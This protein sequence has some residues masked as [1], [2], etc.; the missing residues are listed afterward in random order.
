MRVL[1]RHDGHGI[2]I[3][4]LQLF[5]T[6]PL[7]DH[8]AP[9]TTAA[10]SPA[11]PQADGWY[12]SPVT[13]TLTATDGDGA[14]AGVAGT[15]FAIDGGPWQAYTGPFA[16]AGFGM[17]TVNYRSTDAVGNVETAKQVTFR[18]AAFTDV[19]GTVSGDVPGTLSLSLGSPSAS[20]GAFTPGVARGL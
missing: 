20:L 6:I 5:D 8:D 10:L 9:V 14:V 16:V 17:H 11:Q 12:R 19:P 7:I 3:K 4:E 2:G 1:L 13:V 18:I 15:E